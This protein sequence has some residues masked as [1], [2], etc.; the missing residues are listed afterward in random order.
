MSDS[1][2]ASRTHRR[3]SPPRNAK[4]CALP[5]RKAA[6][7]RALTPVAS[8]ASGSASESDEGYEDI[9]IVESEDE[10]IDQLATPPPKAPVRR[11]RVPPD[12]EITPRRR[13]KRKHYHKYGFFK[14][15]STSAHQI[16]TAIGE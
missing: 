13:A 10:D 5:F 6:K 4:K 3:R 7:Y 11:T 16:S 8:E 15:L 14:K 1:P 2:T 9:S 12:D